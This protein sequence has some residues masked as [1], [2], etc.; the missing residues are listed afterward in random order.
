MEGKEKLSTCLKI[1]KPTQ[2]HDAISPVIAVTQ[3]IQVKDST[4]HYEELEN[5][6]LKHIMIKLLPS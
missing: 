3:T 1:S 6:T 2:Y 4:V 5:N